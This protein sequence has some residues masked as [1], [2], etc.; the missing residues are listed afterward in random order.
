MLGC[1]TPET[2]GRASA[3]SLTRT[4]IGMTED[5]LLKATGARGEPIFAFRHDHDYICRRFVSKANGVPYYFL[6]ENGFLSAV[7]SGENCWLVERTRGISPGERSLPHEQGFDDLL[8]PFKPPRAPESFDY[9]A[10]SPNFMTR[11]ERRELARAEL[12]MWSPIIVLSL[13]LLPL[14]AAGEMYDNAATATAYARAYELLPGMN[15]SE[16]EKRIGKP[17]HTLGDPISYGVYAYHY[18]PADG[19][20][21]YISVG[22]RNSTLEWVRFHYNA[23]AEFTG[24]EGED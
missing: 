23:Y 11:K 7:A 4:E 19:E 14:S 20:S 6:W 22:W 1:A 17:D 5:A 24:I 3:R 13:P 10:K 2:M 8:A 12:I 18:R 16:V 9:T 15:V 21:M